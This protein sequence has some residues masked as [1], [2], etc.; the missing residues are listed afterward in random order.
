MHSNFVTKGDWEC[1][2]RSPYKV[3]YEVKDVWIRLEAIEN[4][5]FVFFDL[6]AGHAVN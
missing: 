6:L 1:Q 4:N 2:S 3:T 5:L